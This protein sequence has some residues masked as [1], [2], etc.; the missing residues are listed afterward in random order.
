VERRHAGAR[1]HVDALRV[2]VER[3]WP[4]D[5]QGVELVSFA[6]GAGETRGQT[7]KRS[8]EFTLGR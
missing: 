2:T 7:V 3:R 8:V 1:A 6:S 5:A 4:G